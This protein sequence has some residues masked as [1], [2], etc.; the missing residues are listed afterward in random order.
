MA[1]RV[2]MLLNNILVDPRY[3][4]ILERSLD[5]LVKEIRGQQLMD[6]SSGK[7]MGEWL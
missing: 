4:V 5:D 3:E 6:V 1:S 2:S 7:T